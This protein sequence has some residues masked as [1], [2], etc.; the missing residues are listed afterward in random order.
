MFS[1]L[2]EV[3]SNTVDG[4]RNG[5]IKTGILMMLG[6]GGDMEKGTIDASEMFYEPEKY[7]ILP[8]DNV[9]EHTKQIA[10][11]VPAYY[12]LNEFKDEN[13]YSRVEEAKTALL[14][15][16]DKKKGDSGS[17]DALN[18]EMQYRP[19]V[20]TEMFLTK[21]AN[22]FPTAEIRRRLTEIQTHKIYEL[23][24][25]KVDLYFDP[26]STLN[27]V[28]YEINERA[29]AISRFP[30]DGDEREGTVVVYEFPAVID[31][32]VPE[33]A[34]IIGCDPFKDDNHEGPSLAAIYVMKTNKYFSSIG[35]DEI[36]AS[37]IGR[38]YFGKNHVNEILHKLSL[39][40]GNA[41]IYFENAVGNVKDYFE[42]IRRLDLLARQPVTVFNKKA[43]YESGPQ[44]MYG[45]PMS[46]QKVK[47][48]A[49]QYL[50]TWLLT[51][52]DNGKRNIDLISDPGLLQ[53]LISFNMDGNF[54][55]VMGLVGC[56]VGLEELYNISKRREATEVESSQ[57]DKDFNR[58]IVKN[59]F[60][61]N[62]KFSKATSAILR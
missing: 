38:P 19:L 6:T 45:Y 47:W 59:K 39:Y 11:F 16:R 46:N 33:G 31:G 28:S 1:N 7:D 22:I 40:Y 15:V 30:Y 2:K 23:L 20:P 55:R 58:L 5:L 62:E 32:R 27:G 3:Y 8:F 21:T 52:R 34:Y 4:L 53:E 57:F 49:L 37:Y 26:E 18:K 17:S 48:E 51:E 42:K 41:K 43:S 60:L 50:R 44:V 36:V 61:F 25:K 35:H 29:T 13:G 54:D 10:Y 12:A 14:K 24:E 9:W 56:I